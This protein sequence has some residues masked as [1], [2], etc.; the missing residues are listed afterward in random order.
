[1]KSSHHASQNQCFDCVGQVWKPPAILLGSTIAGIGLITLLIVL[2]LTVSMGAINGPIFLVNM[3]KIYKPIIFGKNVLEELL[4][5][6]SW[7]NLDLGISTAFLV[8]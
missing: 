5:F 2:Y 1:M 6:L 3:V 8:E 4:Y 7:L